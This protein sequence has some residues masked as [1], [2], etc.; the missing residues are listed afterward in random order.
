MEKHF[1]MSINYIDITFY[2]KCQN[3][4]STPDDLKV[5][6]WGRVEA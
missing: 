5:L 6:M 1:E 4:T 3:R 2:R